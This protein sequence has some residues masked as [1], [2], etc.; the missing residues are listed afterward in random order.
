MEEKEEQKARNAKADR[1]SR[2]S[3]YMEIFKKLMEDTE[4]RKE[5]TDAGISLKSISLDG[6]VKISYVEYGLT[7]K[8]VVS[9]DKPRDE[10]K[11]AMDYLAYHW[12]DERGN[13]LYLDKGIAR[14]PKKLKLKYDKKTGMLTHYSIAG[15]EQVEENPDITWFTTMWLPIYD[16]EMQILNKIFDE[17]WLYIQGER[18]EEDMFKEAEK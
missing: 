3:R 16:T 8:T 13:K 11:L 4:G 18:K 7:E 1:A 5:R 10:L 15:Y 2:I 17:A 6:R 12:T 14:V 9:G